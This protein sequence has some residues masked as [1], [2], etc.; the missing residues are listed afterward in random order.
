M[1]KGAKIRVYDSGFRVQ[2]VGL[3]DDRQA[4]VLSVH[5]HGE[6]LPGV[7]LR[8]WGTGVPRS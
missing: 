2:E 8:V 6:L 7:G 1:I 3:R 4:H 5:L